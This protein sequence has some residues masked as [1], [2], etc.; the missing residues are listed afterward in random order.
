MVCNL[1]PSLLLHG[2]VVKIDIRSLIKAVVRGFR[3]RRAEEVVNVSKANSS[4]QGGLFR[5][6][7]KTYSVSRDTSPAN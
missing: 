3:C 6:S 1:H 2:I 7:F 5:D 4:Q